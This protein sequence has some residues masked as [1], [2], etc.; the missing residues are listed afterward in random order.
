MKRFLQLLLLSVFSVISFSQSQ[1][2]KM[3]GILSQ[4][5]KNIP[6]D[7]L[8]LHFDRNLYHG[9]D[10]IRFQAYIRDSQT[11][12]IETQSKSLYVLLLN[13]DHVTIDSA[14]F[15]ISYS[16]SSGWLKVPEITPLGYYSILAYTSDQM[17]FDPRFAFSTSIR[18]DKINPTRSNTEPEESKVKAAVDLRFLPEGGTYIYGVR[19]RLAFNA[20]TSIG[21]NIQV[22]GDI[23][24]QDGKK[25]TEFKSGPYGPGVV[26]LT[27][28]KGESYYAKPVEAESGNISW[29]LPEP[30]NSGVSMRV[31]NSGTGSVDIMLQG[32]ETTCKDYFL[33]VTM[34]NILIFSK[35]IKLDTLF[36]VRIKTDEIPA[37][38]AFVTLYDNELNQVAERMIFLNASR[39]MKV[40]IGVSKPNARPGSETELT[41]NTTDEKGNNISSIISVSAIDSSLGFY[42]VIPYPDIESSFL[43]DTGFYNNLPQSIKCT[44]LKNIDNKSI[45][46]LMMTYGWRKYTLKESAMAYQEKRSDNYDHLKISNPGHEKKGREVIKLIS[47]EGGGIITLVIDNNREA[48]LPYDSL[49]VFVRQIML[50]PDDD[51][52]R[53]SNPVSFDFPKTREYSNKAKLIRTDSSYFEP[54]YASLDNEMPVFN[55]DSSIMI[56]AVTIKGQRKKPSVY[57]DKNA[58]AFKYAGAFTLYSKDFKG[59]QTF[60]DLTYKLN[61]FFVDKYYRKIYIRAIQYKAKPQELIKVKYRPALIV[62]D[63]I[64]IYD[65][66]YSPIAQLPASEVASI[67]VLRGQQGFITY[68][69]NAADGVILVTTKTG[70]RINGVENSDEESKPANDLLKQIR[71]FRTEVEYYIPSKEQV[72]IVPEYQFRPTLLWK[73]DVYL[74]GTGPVNFKYPNNMGKGS[75]IVFVNGVS[76]TNLVGSGLYR[77][78]VKQ[79][80]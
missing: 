36:S 49:E 15:R 25:I 62:V 70:N 20:V 60:E 38:T 42:R 54:E 68:G 72:E 31:N 33:T 26:E 80:W 59:E 27:P 53:N 48:I 51:L 73:S 58:E 28:V 13:S 3:T 21:K 29:P 56:D 19:Q 18:I 50:L 76:L 37:G 55:P 67:T 23:V 30:E 5:C 43:Y 44:G 4:I 16:T 74:D 77:Y 47:P 71:V 22:S 11:G 6:A 41:I 14:R 34:N 69:E 79:L 12:V 65:R 40:Q 2:E 75:V 64:Q 24:N 78:T 7:Q 57:V 66:T 9:G 32:K 45:D 52:S 61:A 63:G 46:H 35:D 10:T 17:N 39:K 1:T 8:F